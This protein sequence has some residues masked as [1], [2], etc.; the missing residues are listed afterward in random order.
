MTVKR[1]K[2]LCFDLWVKSS[3]RY[4]VCLG[5]RHCHFSSYR[6]RNPRQAVSG[7]CCWTPPR[8][9][10]AQWLSGSQPRARG[11]LYPGDSQSHSPNFITPSLISLPALSTRAEPTPV[12]WGRENEPEQEAHAGA[13]NKL[14]LCRS[15][16]QARERESLHRQLCKQLSAQ[17]L[18]SSYC[19]H[20]G[21]LVQ[22]HGESQQ[23]NQLIACTIQARFPPSL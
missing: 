4:L 23:L 20:V 13:G 3:S 5:F 2:L 10:W 17:R 19:L 11:A 1:I 6:G 21:K 7:G 8:R 22:L 16:P 15:P 14:R 18:H 12:P 9:P